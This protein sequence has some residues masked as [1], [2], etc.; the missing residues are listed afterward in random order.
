VL[1]GLHEK[2]SVMLPMELVSLEAVVVT[3]TPTPLPSEPCQPPDHVDSGGVLAPNSEALQ[4]SCPTYLS[5]WRPLVLDMVWRL[6]P[7]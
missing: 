3:T 2:S 1:Q 5:V 4:K 7:S 6:L